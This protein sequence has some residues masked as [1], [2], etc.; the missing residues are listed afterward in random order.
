M[1]LRVIAHEPDDFEDWVRDQRREAAEP[2]SAEARRGR[3]ILLESQCVDCHTIRGTEAAGVTGPD[4]THFASRN[5]FAGAIF[6]RNA[7]NLTAWVSDA[8]NE[9]PGS[10]MPSGLKDMGL[11][12]EDVK[13]IVAYLQSL[14]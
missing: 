2:R 7:E 4:L 9:K 6:D 12:A 11:D 1:R 8:P 5:T 14:R 3:T 10:L 13:A